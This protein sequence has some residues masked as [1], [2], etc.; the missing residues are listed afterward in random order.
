MPNT[1]HNFPFIEIS[2]FEIFQPIQF[3][4]GVFDSMSYT[5]GERY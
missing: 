2:A 4:T 3:P 5:S 1:Y